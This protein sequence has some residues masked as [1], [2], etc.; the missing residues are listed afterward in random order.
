[1]I[2]TTRHDDVTAYR[3]SWWRSRLIDYGV[4]IFQVRGVLIDTGFPAALREVRAILARQPVRGIFVTHAHEDHA[5][6]VP[7][8][9]ARRLPMALAPATQRLLEQAHPIGFY[10]RFTWQSTPRLQQD[11]LPFTDPAFSLIHAPG[12]A[13]DHHVVWDAETRTLFAGD[14]FL[15][16]KVRLG[17]PYNDPRAEVASIQSLLALAPTRVFC[18]HRGL[19]P[20]G[21][22]LLQAKADWLTTLIGQTEALADAGRSVGAIRAELLGPRPMTHWYSRGEYS[23]DNLIRAILRGR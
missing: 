16:V 23:P 6:N 8:L 13:P 22:A 11:I 9:A 19:L 15:G 10:R 7:W 14:L 21:V 1:V 12:H 5:G 18:A 3:L 4:H 2:E 17:H 20:D